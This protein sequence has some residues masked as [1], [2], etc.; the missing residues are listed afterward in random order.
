MGFVKSI[1]D[2]VLAENAKILAKNGTKN[3]EMKE[4]MRGQMQLMKE[5]M[6]M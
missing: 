3:E 4:L 1:K 5:E 6:K 2:F